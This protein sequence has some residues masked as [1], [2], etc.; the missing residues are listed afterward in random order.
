MRRHDYTFIVANR[1]RSCEASTDVVPDHG[2][3]L[4]TRDRLLEVTT[5]ERLELERA[6]L[7]DQVRGGFLPPWSAATGK[8][9]GC[10]VFDDLTEAGLIGFLSGRL[11]GMERADEE[12][13]WGDEDEGEQHVAGGMGNGVVVL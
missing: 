7:V 10:Q 3:R 1:I 12:A 13:G 9:W 2:S 6:K 4:L 11:L 8:F 5:E